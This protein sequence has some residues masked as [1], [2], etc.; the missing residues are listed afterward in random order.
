MK[1]VLQALLFLTVL[2]PFLAAAQNLRLEKRV[3][4]Y[5]DKLLGRPYGASPLGEASGID[6]DPLVRMDQFDCTTFVETSIALALTGGGENLIPVMNRLR[7]QDGQVSYETRNHF[8]NLDWVKNNAWILQDLTRDLFAGEFATLETVISKSAW[9]EKTVNMSV[10]I[11][12]QNSL[13]YYLPFEQIS[14]HPE[15]LQRLPFVSVAN[16]VRKGWNRKPLIGTELDISHQGF[17]IQKADGV[18]F[19]H[20]SLSKKET[21]EQLLVDYIQTYHNS[22]AVGLQI[23]GF[24]K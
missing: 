14:A 10:R 24:K 1:K 19:R 23:L 11:E 22:T 3:D 4:Y 15:I 2:F 18:Y 21:T 7:Y 13:I 8:T 5:S 12:D 17:I 20:A 9:F 6:A 16:V